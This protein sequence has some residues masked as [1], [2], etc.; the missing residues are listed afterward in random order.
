MKYVIIMQANMCTYQRM[1]RLKQADSGGKIEGS[2][3]SGQGLGHVNGVHHVIEGGVD[4]IGAAKVCLLQIA[5][6][7]VAVLKRITFFNYS[8]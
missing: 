1:Y 5:T 4:E 8:L 7:K 2:S 3:Y 6:R